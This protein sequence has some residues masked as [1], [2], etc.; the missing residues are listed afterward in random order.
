MSLN[1]FSLRAGCKSIGLDYQLSV[2]G[3]TADNL[4]YDATTHR[5]EMIHNNIPIFFHLTTFS[6]PND[7][8]LK[9]LDDIITQA[10]NE[11]EALLNEAFGEK[12]LIYL[13]NNASEIFGSKYTEFENKNYT[14]VWRLIDRRIKEI[15]INT[16]ED[17]KE[18]YLEFINNT[19]IEYFD[20]SAKSLM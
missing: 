10:V 15:Q 11:F 1:T 17:F 14:L 18:I 7:L 8:G 4:I 2:L 12:H 5:I 20:I 6:D 16:P 3:S 19:P 9:F 13:K